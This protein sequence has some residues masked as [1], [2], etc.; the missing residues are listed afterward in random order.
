MLIE[1]ILIGNLNSQQSTNTSWLVTTIK[2][3]VKTPPIFLFRRKHEAE[4]RNSKILAAFKVDLG[5]AIVAHKDSSVKYRSEFYDI[6]SL[7]SP[8]L[9]TRTRLRL[10]K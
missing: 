5:A 3:T 9:I 7:Y 2:V 6:F 8:P 10:S 4:V 1:N